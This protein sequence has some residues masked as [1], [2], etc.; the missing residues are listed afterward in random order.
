MANGSL[1]HER[2]MM[3]L[4][5][6]DRIDNMISDFRPA[7]PLER[8]QFATIVM[9]YQALRLLGS[10]ALARPPAARWTSRRCRC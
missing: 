7:T 8:D 2:T 6:A 9:D 3:W 4:G 5:F 1:G 10:V